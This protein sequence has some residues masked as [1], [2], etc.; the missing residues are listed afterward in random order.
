MPQF[1][2]KG[3][4]GR[5]AISLASEVRPNLSTKAEQ[6]TSPDLPR[7]MPGIEP[8]DLFS[9]RNK[10]HQNGNILG[11]ENLR[12]IYGKSRLER[13]VSHIFFPHVRTFS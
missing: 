11:S 8:S 7:R 3:W 12:T 1:G 13:L 9:M 6:Q 2:L 4:V 5:S 10:D